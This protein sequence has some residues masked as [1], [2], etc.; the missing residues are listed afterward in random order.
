MDKCGVSVDDRLR[1][2]PLFDPVSFLQQS[3]PLNALCALYV[4]R[5]HGLWKAPEVINWV[6]GACQKLVDQKK[7][8]SIEIKDA[9]QL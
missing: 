6:V 5:C 2:D 9:E 4:G 1:H 3:K 8:F 7:E